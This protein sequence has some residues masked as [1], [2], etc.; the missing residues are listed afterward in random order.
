MS[1]TSSSNRIT[2]EVGKGGGL[3]FD[4]SSITAKAGDI[5]TFIFESK[6]HS[7]TQSTFADPCTPKQNGADSG[8]RPL[9]DGVIGTGTPRWEFSVENTDPL[10]FHCGQVVPVSHC[11]LM[12]MVFAINP[13]TDQ[14][15]EAFQGAA[16]GKP[17]TSTIAGSSR[18]TSQTSSSGST[19]SMTEGS[20]STPSASPPSASLTSANSS[21]NKVGIIAGAVVGSLVFV[22]LVVTLTI[23][24]VRR[25]RRYRPY[26]VDLLS[27]GYTRTSFHSSRPPSQNFADT[28]PTPFPLSSVDEK[29]SAQQSDSKIRHTEGL[30]SSSSSAEGA[31]QIRRHADSGWRPVDD[32]IDLPPEYEEAR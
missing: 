31:P 32:T 12:G 1:S 6:N 9:S 24:L 18:T 8:F 15:F 21:S 3:T 16:T 26:S 11:Q 5:I 4:P 7:V 13:T 20:S 27:D 22:A 28:H 2:V 19:R 30:S 10:W 29:S 23:L 25:R 14:S 17:V